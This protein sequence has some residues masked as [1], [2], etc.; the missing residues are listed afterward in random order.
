MDYAPHGD[1][2]AFGPAELSAA[3]DFGGD[4]ELFAQSLRET[5]W[6]EPDGRI[7][8]WLEYAGRLLTEREQSKLRMKAWRERKRNE[9]A[10]NGDVTRNECVTNGERSEL[11]NRTQPNLALDASLSPSARARP[12]SSFPDLI[13]VATEANLRCIP[14]DVA[15]AFWNHFEAMGWIDKNGNSI[16]QWRP[17]LMSW[18][19]KE[20]ADRAKAQLTAKPVGGER[21]EIQ[22]T[23]TLKVL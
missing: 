22:E 8:D 20:Q 16:Q 7:H 2:S 6:L 12:P 19:R 3:A 10:P 14:A 11:P 23:V 5:G 9:R 21:R 4:A 18:W 15:E 17:K 1:V 13:E